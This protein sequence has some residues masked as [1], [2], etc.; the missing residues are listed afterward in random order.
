MPG[1]GDR[2]GT[3]TRCARNVEE[4]GEP[5]TDSIHGVV[6]GGD[7]AETPLLEVL[8]GLEHFRLGVHDE[9]SGHRYRFTNRPTTQN[10][11]LERLGT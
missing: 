1:D 2:A 8:E 3:P 10:E 7:R 6:V 4:P 9:W 5:R 11:H